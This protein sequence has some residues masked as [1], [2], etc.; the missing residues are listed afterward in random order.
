MIR[1][2]SNMVFLKQ[3]LNRGKLEHQRILM[4]LFLLK[5]VIFTKIKLLVYFINDLTKVAAHEMKMDLKPDG[6]EMGTSH[7]ITFIYTAI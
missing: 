6:D 3:T 5:I 2:A 4:K 1:F 7:P